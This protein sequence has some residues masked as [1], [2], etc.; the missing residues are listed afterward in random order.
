MLLDTVGKSCDVRSWAGV[1]LLSHTTENK[2]PW[3][4][5]YTY[6]VPLWYFLFHLKHWFYSLL[7]VITHSLKNTDLEQSQN[8]VK[9]SKDWK[10]GIKLILFLEISCTGG[11]SLLKY[12]FSYLNEEKKCVKECWYLKLRIA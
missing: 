9:K 2:G 10:E 8:T 11:T 7:L 5:T 4:T 3:N 6:Q 12:N 1:G